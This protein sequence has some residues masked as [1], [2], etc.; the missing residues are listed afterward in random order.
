MNFVQDGI[1]VEKIE[2]RIQTLIE[3]GHF[4][5]ETL[6]I[7]GY[8][9]SKSTIE[10]LQSFRA[11]A[12]QHGLELWFSATISDN[13]GFFDGSVVPP[14]LVHLLDEIA[15]VICLQPRGDFIH[16]NLTKDHDAQVVENT[17]LKVDPKILLLAEDN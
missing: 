3:Q 11:F 8:D 12:R 10:D 13:N 4:H 9:F 17:H 14:V 7:D 5:A 16:L 2:T 15:I 1:H 6:V